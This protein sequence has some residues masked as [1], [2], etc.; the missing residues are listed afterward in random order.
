MHDLLV[1]TIEVDELV[2]FFGFFSYL[3]LRGNVEHECI[4]APFESKGIPR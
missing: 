1:F 4:L 2:I 3:H